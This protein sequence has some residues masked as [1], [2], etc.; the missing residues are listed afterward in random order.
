MS[1]SINDY[2]TASAEWQNYKNAY[3]IAGQALNNVLTTGTVVYHDPSFI[4]MFPNSFA[5]YQQYLVNLQ[6]AINSFIST[7]PVEPS[8]SG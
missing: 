2:Q 7:L 5:A 6:T 4:A 3:N 8:L 1:L